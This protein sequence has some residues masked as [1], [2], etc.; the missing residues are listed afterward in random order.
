MLGLKTLAAGRES[1]RG[2]VLSYQPALV[3]PLTTLCGE[4]R[5]SGTK[6]ILVLNKNLSNQKTPHPE[7]G[8]EF[9]C[10][11]P[12]SVQGTGL[13]SGSTQRKNTC[14]NVLKVCVFCITARTLA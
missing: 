14:E 11:G 8:R 7:T 4:W 2:R 6:A 5:P 1:P 3:Y 13:L 10:G 9:V 12:A